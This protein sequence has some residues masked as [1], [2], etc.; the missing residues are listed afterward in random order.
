ML[1]RTS[2]GSGRTPIRA[3]LS[4][5][6]RTRGQSLVEFALVMPIL[7]FLTLIAL[8]FGRVYLGY[9][10]LQ[11]MSRNAANFA[12]NNPTAWGATPDTNAQ[13][14]YRN[15]ILQDAAA[16][17]CQLPKDGAGKAVVPTPT[18]T[19][20]D[21]NGFTSDLGDTAEVQI[22]CTFP[23]ITPGIAQVVGSNVA[24]SASSR[25]PV[26]SSMTAVGTGGGGGGTAPNAA[27]SGNT[28]I[29][30][31]GITGI[32]P[33][34]VDFRDTS[35][36]N[37]TSWTWTFPDDSSSATVQDPGIH[38]FTVPGTWTVT[39]V[40]GNLYGT[41]NATMVVTVQASST[42][43]FHADKT[44]IVPGETV[45]F[46]DDSTPGGTAVVWSFGTGEGTSTLASPTHTYNTPGTYTVNLKVTYP[47]PT[48]DVLT[49]K[50]GYINVAVGSCLVPSLTGVHINNAE[51]IWQGPPYNF[52]GGVIRA[53]GAP[54]GN[55]IITAQ[56][57]TGGTLIPCNSTV[58][59]NRP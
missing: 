56:D 34:A 11:N 19:D 2:R 21:G 28:V 18:F 31:N 33:F 12:A 40:A 52:T 38:T 29:T 22:G 48:G 13:L 55:F 35:G 45:T 1:R 15:Q 17:N 54:N 49:S 46:T 43:N 58:T 5:R 57:R 6:R 4:Q 10:N 9:I 7:L 26:A 32:A 47:S 23:V 37:P 14:R 24:V 39:M 8:D 50:V 59:V 44:N 3:R 36:G 27:F 25:F 41:D 30:P 16:I 20:R 53:P 42:V 51:G